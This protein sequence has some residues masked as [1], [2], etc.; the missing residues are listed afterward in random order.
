MTLR[1]NYHHSSSQHT[2]PSLLVCVSHFTRTKVS[3]FY[4]VTL[5]AP[6]VLACCSCVVFLHVIV[7]IRYGPIIDIPS[8]LR[9]FLLRYGC[10]YLSLRAGTKACRVSNVQVGQLL[11]SK[12][13]LMSEFEAARPR[14]DIIEAYYTFQ[15]GSVRKSD[16]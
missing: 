2:L 10:E 13:A 6:Y 1:H 8:E 9:I 7:W 3:T 5:C 11:V 15:R 16:R 12:L 4:R 14:P